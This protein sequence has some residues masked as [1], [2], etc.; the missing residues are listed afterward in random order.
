[1]VVGAHG[2][3]MIPFIVPEIVLTEYNME[4]MVPIHILWSGAPFWENL[5]CL[6]FRCAL[7]LE[8]AFFSIFI[9]SAGVAV[10][11]KTVEEGGKGRTQMCLGTLFILI[12]YHMM[13]LCGASPALVIVL[14]IVYA[15]WFF[16]TAIFILQYASAHEGPGGLY[17]KINP[18]N[19][20]DE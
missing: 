19:E 17:D 9:W 5:G 8:P 16:F 20:L 13:S 10:K 15:V 12:C 2:Y 3:V 11:D 7:Y 14:R 18:K 6:I 1:M 4:R